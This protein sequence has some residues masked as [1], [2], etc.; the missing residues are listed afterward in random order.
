MIRFA[1]GVNCDVRSVYAFRERI[2]LSDFLRLT[3]DTD[4][5]DL[6]AMFFGAGI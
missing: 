3:A 4:V 2:H 1:L 6:L 5:S